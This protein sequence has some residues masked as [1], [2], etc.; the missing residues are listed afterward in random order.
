M[1]EQPAE[2]R[3]CQCDDPSCAKCL[4]VNCKDDECPIHT[5]EEKKKRRKYFGIGDS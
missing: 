4:T 3:K 5:M 1:N 2:D